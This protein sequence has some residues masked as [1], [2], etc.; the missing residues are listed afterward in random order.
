[1]IFIIGISLDIFGLKWSII[2][3]EIGYILYIVANI[4]P[5]P[6]FMYISAALVGFVAAPLWASQAVYLGRI[7]HYYAQHKHQT[8]EVYVSLFFVIFFAIFGTNI[9]WCNLISYF[10]LNQSNHHRK[11]I[12]EYISIQNQP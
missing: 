12:V 2:L 5:L 6:V 3:S 11:L 10:V 7:A 8:P 9:F 4:Y 1:S